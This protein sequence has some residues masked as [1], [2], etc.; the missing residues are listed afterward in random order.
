MTNITRGDSILQRAQVRSGCSLTA[1]QL[2]MD[3]MMHSFV[4]S[5]TDGN[6][7]AAMMVGGLAGRFV[8]L[9]TLSASSNFVTRPLAQGLAL[10]G[11][12]S[13]FEGTHR[14]LQVAQGQASSDILRWGGELGLGRGIL[15]SLITFTSLHAVG[16]L[17]KNHNVVL[18]HAFQSSTLVASH[19]IAARLGLQAHNENDLM[20]QLVEAEISNLQFGLSKSLIHVA[21]PAIA[22]FERSVELQSEI[23]NRSVQRLERNPFLVTR[24]SALPLPAQLNIIKEINF[25]NHDHAL[26]DVLAAKGQDVLI[27][28]QTLGEAEAHSALARLWFDL[29]PHVSEYRS[30]RLQVGGVKLAYGEFS[31][32]TFQRLKEG[33]SEVITLPR[34]GT[35]I[36]VSHSK[37]NFE[38]TYSFLRSL[39]R[40]DKKRSRESHL[41]ENSNIRT[42]YSESIAFELRRGI[43]TH[44]EQMRRWVHEVSPEIIVMNE[45]LKRNEALTPDQKAR[46][47]ELKKRDSQW[48][49]EFQEF[50]NLWRWMESNKSKAVKAEESE[51]PSVRQVLHDLNNRLSALMTVSADISL[52]EYGMVVSEGLIHSTQTSTHL[53][54]A[55]AVNEGIGMALGVA[56]RAGIEIKGLDGMPE[57]FQQ[58][59]LN[60]DPHIEFALTDVM[61]NLL[62]NAIRYADPA[63]GS[64]AIQ[65]RITAHFLREGNLEI[66][67]FDR[68]IGILPE[69]F[70]RLGEEGFREARKE[71]QGSSGHGIAS[72]INILRERGW[73]P[74][75]VRS[76]VGE[77]SAFRFV[78]PKSDFVKAEGFQAD[79]GSDLDTYRP[80][81]PLS[82]LERNLSEGFLV[83]AASIDM[84]I[85]LLVR[86]IPADVSTLRIPELVF[87][88][89]L[90]GSFEHR[91]ALALH[92]LLSGALKPEEVV[93]VDN[94]CGSNANLFLSLLRMGSR[95]WVKEPDIEGHAINFV[96]RESLSSDMQARLQVSEL[97]NIN[98]PMPSPARV[99]YWSNPNYGNFALP[100][101]SRFVEYLSR[102]VGVG[103]YLVI[104]NGRGVF[105]R[106]TRSFDFDP[107]KWRLV[108][109][110]PSQ[111][112][113]QDILDERVLPTTSGK[114]NAI[115]IYQ[116]IQ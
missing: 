32:E 79:P 75:W 43:Y 55:S 40:E 26:R 48:L 67:V 44:Y 116:R 90:D 13:A 2:R 4:S 70:D 16:G 45:Q 66:T 86:D 102:D 42:F 115:F 34:Q 89:I 19:E 60:E 87:D 20:T 11:E 58:V 25:T 72:V 47:S 39:Y 92:R 17:S 106:E 14:L 108:Y 113:S 74:L 10:F 62:S 98:E 81:D 100:E 6:M 95:V 31:G 93:A 63:K 84:A 78:I 53:T 8:K 24:M 37:D 9:G 103:G 59:L 76:V 64:E 111:T 54:V 35:L 77:G 56:S 107:L 99:A 112:G 82:Y 3:S 5:A 97:S 1:S 51:G 104:Q 15:H 30:L 105:E 83:P 109:Q 7:L 29:E 36:E 114:P 101:G 27:V 73:G 28:P 94:A 22:S 71:V 23:A 96:D 80:N 41:E 38:E 68:G 57:R 69:N 50:R 88:K 18:Q 21:F 46:L 91:R 65:P 33:S 49:E 12:A 61:G 85:P 52:L 110:S